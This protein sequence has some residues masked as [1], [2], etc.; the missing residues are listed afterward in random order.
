M[1]SQNDYRYFERS[2]ER[3]AHEWPWL[4]DLICC[5]HDD[6]IEGCA[7]WE[8]ADSFRE[9]Y[10]TGTATAHWSRPVEGHVRAA[11]VRRSDL[12]LTS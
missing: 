6:G 4:V 8:Q 2:E 12:V 11:I 3:L 7:T 5:G 9:S 1:S 10:C